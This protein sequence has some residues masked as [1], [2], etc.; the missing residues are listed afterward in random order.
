MTLVSVEPELKDLYRGLPCQTTHRV[1]VF[2]ALRI[3]SHVINL[4][5]RSFV[6]DALKL[7]HQMSSNVS[8]SRDKQS[9]NYIIR[10]GL[11]GGF[12]GCV[13]RVLFT[14]TISSL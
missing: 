8:K 11:A 13:V 10:S 9:L 6:C 1:T 2:K 4:L 3:P 14:C 5:H 12:A 7:V